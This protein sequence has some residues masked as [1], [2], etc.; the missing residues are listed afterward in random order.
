MNTDVTTNS[1]TLLDTL[2]LNNGWTLS[3]V[4]TNQNY[5]YYE[6]I[7]VGIIPENNGSVSFNAQFIV[8]NQIC[9]D[10]N[11]QYLCY[12]N[13]TGGNNAESATQQ[14]SLTLWPKDRTGPSNISGGIHGKMT[15]FLGAN[16]ASHTSVLFAPN[17]YNGFGCQAWVTGSY[18]N[19]LPIDGI[20]F[21]F[22]N[23]I[24]SGQIEVWGCN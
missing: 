20:K 22:E 1:R 21:E 16:Y 15:L 5:S 24:N 6:L 14:T 12:G 11:Y 17:A 18:M 9:S 10:T 4:F 23:G 3:S 8:Q 13:D 19:F 7:I 2:N